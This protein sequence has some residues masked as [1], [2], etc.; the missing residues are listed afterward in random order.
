MIQSLTVAQDH[1][2][3]DVFYFWPGAINLATRNADGGP[4]L[5]LSLARYSG[6][7][8]RG[9]AG[10][11]SLRANLYLRLQMASVDS[12]LLD[13]VAARLQQDAG[14]SV[15][16]RPMPINRLE[17][18]LLLPVLDTENLSQIDVNV[19]VESVDR[20][21]GRT[22][23]WTERDM[24][25][26][27]DAQTAELLEHQLRD[28][29]LAMSLSYRFISRVYGSTQAAGE[30]DTSGND[31]LAEELDE[32]LAQ[33]EAAAAAQT[34]VLVAIGANAVPIRLELNEYPDR[35]QRYDIDAAL[36][37]SYPSLSVYCYDFREQLRPDLFEKAVEI[38]AA[39]VAGG[40]TVYTT[41][42]NAYQP[43]LYAQTVKFPF[44]VNLRQPYRW[45]TH[46]I[47]LSGEQLSSDWQQGDS[48]VGIIDASS[49]AEQIEQN[50]HLTQEQ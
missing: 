26:P 1:S 34:P 15:T 41:R 36:P 20:E 10:E 38:Q 29:T 50:L 21:A 9:D 8:V 4:E 7:V 24:F 42:F 11:T 32:A 14:H 35:I 5:A 43:D 30:L 27:L 48:W 22:P 25:I 19:I 2:Q 33:I 37:P 46:E 28:G 17:A 40:T 39:G 6:S 13:I 12:D 44:A 49:S 31:E 3:S 23:F 16:L 45:R 18:S 47:L